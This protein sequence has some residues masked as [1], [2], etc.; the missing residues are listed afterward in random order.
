[1]I[2]TT[3][4][5]TDWKAIYYIN[6]IYMLEHYVWKFFGSNITFIGFILL[7]YLPRDRLCG[8]VVRVSAQQIQRSRVRFSALPD[9]SE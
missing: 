1:M 5:G 3:Q 9:F 7:Y 4:M 2:L 8:L 6:Y